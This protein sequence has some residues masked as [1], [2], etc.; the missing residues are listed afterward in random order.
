MNSTRNC[1][2]IHLDTNALNSLSGVEKSKSGFLKTEIER[3][4]LLLRIIHV[5]VDERRAE[6][7][8]EYQRKIERVLSSLRK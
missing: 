1:V 6:E 5:Q 8:Q 3:G 7:N 4:S 2:R